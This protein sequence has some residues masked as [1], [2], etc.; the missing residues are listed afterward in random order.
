MQ[1][2]ELVSGFDSFRFAGSGAEEYCVYTAG[3]GPAVL[4]THELPGMTPS[5]IG[6]AQDIVAAGFTVFLPLLF[7]RPGQDLGVLSAFTLC[8]RREFHLFAAG[9]RGPLTDWLRELCAHVHALRG[10]PGIGLIGMCLT[11]GMVFALCASPAVLAAVTSQPGLPISLFRGAKFRSDL[12]TAP[13]D[14]DAAKTR[15]A[16][17]GI[18]I[19]G[20]R[21]SSDYGCPAERFETAKREFGEHFKPTTYPTPDRKHRLPFW[22]HSVLTGTYRRDQ[23]ESHPAHRARRAVIAYLRERLLGESSR[24]G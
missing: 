21:Y 20:F 14:L 22:S 9:T 13:D 18:D 12:G 23:P 11:G 4:L 7:G 10:G 1:H 24:A 5:C 17:D 6:F 2:C 16:A 15:V 3:Q 8:V 19:L